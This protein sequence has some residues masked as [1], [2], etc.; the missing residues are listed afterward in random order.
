MKLHI[1]DCDFWNKKDENSYGVSSSFILFWFPRYQQSAINQETEHAFK[2]ASFI[3]F[4]FK[5]EWSIVSKY[6]FFNLNLSG[7]SNKVMSPENYSKIKIIKNEIKILSYKRTK[8]SHVKG[9]AKGEITTPLCHW[10]HREMFDQI[11]NM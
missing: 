5:D 9:C 3:D 11:W 4:Y 1:W 10:Y 7:W 2:V 6:Y 8:S